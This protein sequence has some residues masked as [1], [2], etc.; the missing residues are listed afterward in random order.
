MYERSNKVLGT[1]AYATVYLGK[2]KDKGTPVALKVIPRRLIDGAAQAAAERQL[3]NGEVQVGRDRLR[4]GLCTK[5]TEFIEDEKHYVIVMELMGGGDLF[6]F[7]KR[8]KVTE[9]E[10]QCI[11][12]QVLGGLQ[13]MHS[14]NIGHFDL[15][16]EN[17]LLSQEKPMVV[18][19][20]D[21]GIST[22]APAS[23]FKVPGMLRA[24]PGTHATQSQRGGP[25][26]KIFCYNPSV[27][28]RLLL[29]GSIRG[30]GFGEVVLLYH[31]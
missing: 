9:G 12:R 2:C 14:Q 21:F 24:T 3:L 11:T 30:L 17:F 25:A 5:T 29:D 23:C 1:G 15:K 16:P 10:A 22:N 6:D 4:H 18:K 27:L 31:S 7:L 19:L 13:H 26:F 8:R 20:C 28:D